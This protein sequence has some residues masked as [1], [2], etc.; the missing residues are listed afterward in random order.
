MKN[1]YLFTITLALL[2][3]LL[4]AQSAWSCAYTWRPHCSRKRQVCVSPFWL[5]KQAYTGCSLACGVSHL[6]LSFP[7]HK[8]LKNVRVV[9]FIR[10][11]WLGIAVV[12][13]VKLKRWYN[14]IKSAHDLRF[15]NFLLPFTANACW[16]CWCS[17]LY[18]KKNPFMSS[19]MGNNTSNRKKYQISFKSSLSGHISQY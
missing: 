3:P 9:F 4:T 15:Q 16:S 18:G 10:V 5:V 8:A 14:A 7:S 12:K 17:T 19:L 13:K 11:K 1:L 6:K 2:L